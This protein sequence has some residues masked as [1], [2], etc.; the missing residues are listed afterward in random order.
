LKAVGLA[1]CWVATCLVRSRFHS[2]ATGMQW[3]SKQCHFVA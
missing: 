3:C 1:G 2:D